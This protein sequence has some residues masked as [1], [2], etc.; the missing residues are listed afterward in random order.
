MQLPARLI[1][2]DFTYETTLDLETRPG[3]VIN[4]QT[5]QGKLS[6]QVY[7]VKIVN[8]TDGMS[9]E[10]RFCNPPTK[11]FEVCADA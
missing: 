6:L 4:L 3:D 2:R 11:P 8:G 10:V 5:N 9:L 1:F 7:Q